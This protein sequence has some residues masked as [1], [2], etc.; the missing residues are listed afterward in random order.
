N[1][2]VESFGGALTF[3]FTDASGNPITPTAATPTTSTQTITT[4]DGST[5]TYTATTFTQP[6]VPAGFYISID[7]FASFS[8]F[9]TLTAT[10]SGSVTLTVTSTFAKIDLSGDLNISDLG[11]L[12][13][14]TGELVVDY[15]GGVNNLAIYGALKIQT[16]S[17]F[18]KLE[19]VGLHVDGA[20][21]FVLN[22][23]N[24]P[25]T[26]YLPDPLHPHVTADATEF[27][28]TDT[29]MFEVTIGGT[30]PGTF[31]TLDYKAGGHTIL[32]MQAD[33]DLK[34]DSSGLT[35]FA[36]I[37]SMTVGSSGSPFLTLSGN[38]LFIIND[39]GVAAELNLA[40]SAQ[41]IPDVNLDAHF[42]LVLNTT[43][44]DVTYNI[45]NTL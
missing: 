45:P 8:A 42:L 38:G 4:S 43:G 34:I 32:A 14:A 36:D 30:S 31:A 1:T 27:D 11:D 10:I 2:P 25:Q 28:I 13:T 20:A 9:G 7:G 19:S 24:S 6:T 12:A 16:G 40:L 18:A 39:L 26:V 5:H 35:M 41:N 29:H 23:T 21:T 17:G 37:N 44:T 22:T 33:L 3:G 15:S